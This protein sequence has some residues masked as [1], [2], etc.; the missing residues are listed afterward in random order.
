MVTLERDASVVLYTDGLVE[1]RSQSLDEGIDRLRRVL[2]DLAPLPLQEVCDEVLRRMGGDDDD[3]AII[4]VRLH[5]QD[6]PRPPEA[7]PRRIPPNVD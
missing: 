6:R 5:R 2:G 7:G 4:A 1:R 3:I